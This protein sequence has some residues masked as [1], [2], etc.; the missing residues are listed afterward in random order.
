MHVTY[1]VYTF[2]VIKGV[3]LPHPKPQMLATHDTGTQY[4]CPIQRDMAIPFPTRIPRAEPA[5]PL[6]GINKNEAT[7]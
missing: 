1:S 7:F 5:R 6:Q 2:N 3:N 4:D